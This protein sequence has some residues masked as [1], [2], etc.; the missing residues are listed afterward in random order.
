MKKPF[1]QEFVLSVLIELHVCC[2]RNQYS[3]GG[4]WVG[5]FK[6]W[7]WRGGGGVERGG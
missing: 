4:M 3:M 2:A 5:D 7:G 1:A 6:D